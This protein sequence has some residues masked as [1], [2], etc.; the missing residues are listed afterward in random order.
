MSV[1]IVLH[2]QVNDKKKFVKTNTLHITKEYNINYTKDGAVLKIH[3][4][5]EQVFYNG[6]I[7]WLTCT[8]RLDKEHDFA[9]CGLDTEPELA[10]I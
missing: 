3:D 4:V 8:S 1:P 5:K 2:G 9:L 7:D 10:D 6:G